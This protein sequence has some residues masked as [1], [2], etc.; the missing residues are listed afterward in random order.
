MYEYVIKTEYQGRGT[1]HWHIAAWITSYVVL[2]LL[3]GS[4]IIGAVWGA[5]GAILGGPDSFALGFG[6]LCPTKIARGVAVLGGR[7]GESG[8]LWAV[9]WATVGKQVSKQPKQ[10]SERPAG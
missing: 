10:A 2:R 4:L 1:Q 6:G 8:R 7:V 5:W 9:V 3:A